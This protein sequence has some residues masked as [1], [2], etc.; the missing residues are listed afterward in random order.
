[1]KINEAEFNVIDISDF[2]YIRYFRFIEMMRN[3][4]E[5]SDSFNFTDFKTEAIKLMNSRDLHNLSVLIENINIA[6]EAEI[7]SLNFA[8]SLITLIEDEKQS[9]I[10]EEFHKIKMQNLIDKGL[11]I[12]VITSTLMLFIE[13]HPFEFRN[14]SEAVNKLKVILSQ[15]SEMEEL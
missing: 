1:M 6:K 15:N 2:W 9:D 8:F 5:G 4:F 13:R 11:T 12:G 14:L 10:S 7:D 3:V